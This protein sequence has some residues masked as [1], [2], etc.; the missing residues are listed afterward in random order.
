MHNTIILLYDYARMTAKEY[1]RFGMGG[2]IWGTDSVAKEIRRWDI[3]DKQEALQ[4]LAKY[5]CRYEEVA[6]GDWSVE[7]YAL[8]YCECDEDGE[9]AAG[10]DYVLA[11]E[12]G[13]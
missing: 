9:F 5:R 10:S 13:K 8:Q 3:S 7:E 11:E 12:E 4:E 6:G 1:K 2:L